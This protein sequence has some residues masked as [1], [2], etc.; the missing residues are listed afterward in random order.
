VKWLLLGL[1]ILLVATATAAATPIRINT[2]SALNARRAFANVTVA[3]YGGTRC[4][5][6]VWSVVYRLPAIV[7]VGGLGRYTIDGCSGPG[8]TAGRSYNVRVPAA[9]AIG[10]R[11]SICITAINNNQYG[12]SVRHRTCKT[13]RAYF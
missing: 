1:A 5:V 13:F 8:Q 6:N 12:S 11:Y 9:L 3:P 7:R 10:R 4:S 2:A